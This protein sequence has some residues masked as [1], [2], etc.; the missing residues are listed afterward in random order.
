MNNESQSTDSPVTVSST[1]PLNNPTAPL[2]TAQPDATQGTIPVTVAK[3]PKSAKFY[4]IGLVVCL[5]LTVVVDVLLASLFKGAVDVQ[6]RPGNDSVAGLPMIFTLLS[7]SIWSSVL[8]G[9]CVMG[10]MTLAQVRKSRKE[11]AAFSAQQSFWLRSLSI[12]IFIA[13]GV[14]LMLALGAIFAVFI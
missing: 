11:G 1:N 6:D 3:K 4:L 14:G 10:G 2:N 8:I 12:V 5:I 9:S 7:S 13:A